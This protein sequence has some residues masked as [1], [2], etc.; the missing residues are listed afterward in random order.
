MKPYRVAGLNANAKE[1]AL[2][3]YEINIPCNFVPLKTIQ[4]FST[5]LIGIF[6]FMC[7]GGVL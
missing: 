7:N 6:I 3:M 1:S 2:K 5:L 4:K